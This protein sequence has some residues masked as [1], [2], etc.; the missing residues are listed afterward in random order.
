MFRWSQRDFSVKQTIY[1][2]GRQS[3]TA[4]VTNVL[5]VLFLFYLFVTYSSESSKYRIIFTKKKKL[6][7]MLFF[8]DVI[9]KQQPFLFLFFYCKARIIRHYQTNNS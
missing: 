8:I 3:L 9:F 2:L 5:R 4:D 1:Y 6:L 7:F